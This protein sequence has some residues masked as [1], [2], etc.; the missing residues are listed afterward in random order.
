MVSIPEKLLKQLVPDHRLHFIPTHS[1]LSMRGLLLKPKILSHPRSKMSF[2]LIY[3]LDTACSQDS[4]EIGEPRLIRGTSPSLPALH[5]PNDPPE[6]NA[7]DDDASDDEEHT[8]PVQ[9]DEPRAPLTT[10]DRGDHGVIQHKQPLPAH[11]AQGVIGKDI[12]RDRE[13]N[14][15]G[16]KIVQSH[17]ETVVVT[18]ESAP[19]QPMHP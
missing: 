16:E 5:N 4:I 8:D 15:N 3:H 6:Y 9:N 1:V 19:V 13:L 7:M 2:D 17:G 14:R 12:R 10:A 11:H 18:W